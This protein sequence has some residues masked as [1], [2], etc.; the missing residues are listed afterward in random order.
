MTRTSPGFARIVRPTPET[1]SERTL[2]G[3]LHVGLG[4]AGHA[5]VG[6]LGTNRCLLSEPGGE[7]RPH[8]TRRPRQQDELPGLGRDNLPGSRTGSGSKYR[9]ALEDER[10]GQHLFRCIGIGVPPH[11]LLQEREQSCVGAQCGPKRL[12]CRLTGDVVVRGAESPGRDDEVVCGAY[13]RQTLAQDADV[14]TDADRLGDAIAVPLDIARD[15]GGVGVDAQALDQLRA[16][17]HD[18]RGL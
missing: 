2:G 7:H 6:G 15:L 14:V 9:R 13:A 17:R 10:L 18:R 8:L 11:E 3:E 12:C 1:V 4:K 5:K 16:Y